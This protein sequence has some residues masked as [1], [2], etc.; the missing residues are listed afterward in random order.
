MNVRI[1][2]WWIAV[3]CL[4]CG[5][6]AASEFSCGPAFEVPAEQVARWAQDSDGLGAIGNNIALA[7]QAMG[8]EGREFFA[9]YFKPDN[10]SSVN[11]SFTGATGS[12]LQLS[13]KWWRPRVEAWVWRFSGGGG[14]YYQKG[15]LAG[16]SPWWAH[17]YFGRAVLFQLVQGQQTEV[18]RLRICRQTSHLISESLVPAEFAGFRFPVADYDRI[19]RERPAP[20]ICGDLLDPP[21]GQKPFAPVYGSSSH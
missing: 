12:G 13:R 18:M 8:S 15:T 19:L 7:Q 17:V 1:V 6:V 14:F 3:C 4:T 2:S 5:K 20:A 9:T 10:V 21:L 16:R 11:F